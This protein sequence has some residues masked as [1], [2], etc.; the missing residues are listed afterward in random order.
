MAPTTAPGSTTDP[1]YNPD[2]KYTPRPTAGAQAT[3]VPLVVGVSGYL[4]DPDGMAL[5]T[6]D[7]D[8]LG[9]ATCLGGCADNWPPLTVAPDQEVTAGAGVVG[10]LATIER[11][12]GAIQVTYNARPLYYFAGDSAPGDTNGH[13]IGDVWFLA[14]P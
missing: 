5:Y 8:S 10:T 1:Y 3:P 12:D 9:E 11:T 7:N 14:Q 13:G 2:D 6:F 4:I